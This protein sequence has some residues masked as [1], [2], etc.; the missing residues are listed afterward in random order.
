MGV[1]V[2]VLVLGACSHRTDTGMIEAAKGLV[3]PESEILEVSDNS[4]GLTIEAGN[5]W[6]ALQISDGGLGPALLEA[7][8]DRASAGG[9]DEQY[10]CDLRDGVQLG[11]A[12]DDL[13]VDVSVGT[14]DESV[15]GRIRIQRLGDGNPWPPD[16]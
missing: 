3:P 14:R 10:R 8:E 12:R 7:V 13:E 9:W 2:A 1:F 4:K 6:A 15:R 11:Y 16:C 5:Y